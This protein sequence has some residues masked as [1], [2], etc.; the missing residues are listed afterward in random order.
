MLIYQCVGILV[1][2]LVLK[3][4]IVSGYHSSAHRL[5]PLVLGLITLYNFYQIY[6]CVIGVP[7]ALQEL[8]DLLLLQVLLLLVFY[9]ADFMELSMPKILTTIAFSGTLLVDAWMFYFLDQKA[10][11]V[12]VFLV[13]CLIFAV[14][15]VGMATYT[16]FHF[17]L[18]KMDHFTCNILYSCIVIMTIA[19]G[20]DITGIV[21]GQY[22]MPAALMVVSLL[23]Y[24]LLKSGRLSDTSRMLK[25]NLFDNTNEVTLL[26]DDKMYFR[27]CTDVARSCFPKLIEEIENHPTN[28]RYKEA[29]ME[30]AKD[31]AVRH[32][33]ALEDKH[34]SCKITSV[35]QK[36][37]CKGYILNFFDITEQKAQMQSMEQL[38]NKA[39]KQSR[40][41]SQFLAQMSHDLR[42]PLHAVLGGSEILLERQ[43]LTPRNRAMVSQIKAAGKTLLSEVNEI[44]DF[45]KLEAGRLELNEAPYSFQQLLEELAHQ[46]FVDLKKSSVKFRMRVMS[47]YP[48]MVIGDEM[49]V[50]RII[51]N[52]LS[53][54]CKYTEVG[55]VQC[56]VYCII[57]KSIDSACFKIKVKDTGCGMT[58]EQ[59]DDI[60]DEYVTY[61]EKANG[62]GLGMSIVRQLVKMMG[63]KVVVESEQYKG[64]TVIIDI[65][66]KLV[67]DDIQ[68]AS[69][70]VEEDL[71]R[72]ALIK[73]NLVLPHW[74]YPNGRV[75][76]ADDI[77]LNLEI[78]KELSIPWKFHVDTVSSG[79]EAIE[80]AKN[81]HYDLIVLDQMMPGMNGIETAREIKKLTNAPLLALTADISEET[82]EACLESGFD[83]FLP[84][85]IDMVVFQKLIENFMPEKGRQVFVQTT[86]AFGNFYTATHMQ[87]AYFRMLESFVREASVLESELENYAKSD[88]KMFVTKIHGIKG[89]CKQL[90]QAQMAEL[91]EILEMAAKTSNMEFIQRHIKNF[92]EEL[93]L[94]ICELRIEMEALGIDKKESFEERAVSKQEKNE[95]FKKLKEG[96][97]T[98][99]LTKIEKYIDALSEVELTDE[100]KL[101]LQSA[102]EAYDDFDYETG[103]KLFQ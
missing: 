58:K 15:I 45:S 62:V 12:P 35:Y 72:E 23:I 66:Q 38:K 36:S 53:N 44:L 63:G 24:F 98:Y 83:E 69:D 61:Q 19:F 30:W 13:A 4:Y 37:R 27:D 26:F 31:E 64:T 56:K 22:I 68:F 95:L 77:E 11:Y 55:M 96:F 9:I 54:A 8:E 67:N 91:S 47:D 34:Y 29:L 6:Q 97:E 86:S 94:V 33:F 90:G 102:K 50:R 52:V 75:L 60:F 42:S 79:K 14:I 16:Y 32:Q 84:K 25:E 3:E 82:R 81:T 74:I 100:E 78:F 39:E 41:K 21:K 87:N 49:R 85:P 71:E 65:P 48:D 28:Y 46:C 76:V 5:L 7:E 92:L 73:D 93:H 103:Q 43:S 101:L 40:M 2:F 57:N 59:L 1:T 89:A 20:C 10:Y 99:Q 80:A 18:K 88:L 17:S 70:I 51:Q